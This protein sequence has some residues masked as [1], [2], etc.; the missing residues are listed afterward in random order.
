VAKAAMTTICQAA[1]DH[2]WSG[3]HAEAI[4]QMR[5]RLEE[6]AAGGNL[7]RGP[8]GIVDIEFLVQMLQLKHGRRNVR[9]RSPNTLVALVALA[10]AGALPQAD[11]EF[12]AQSYRFLRTVEGRLRL[13]NSTARDRLPEDPTELAKLAHLLR[14]PSG[15][16]VLADFDRYTRETRERFNR[17]FD[18]EGGS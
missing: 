15:D 13:M 17:I 9:V 7:K 2:R 18:K 14:A 4:R 6:T 3:A 12:L 5:H 11:A 10:R 16:A 8:G 1:F